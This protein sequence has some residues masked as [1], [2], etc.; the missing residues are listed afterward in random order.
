MFQLGSRTIDE[1]K[2]TQPG[3][4]TSVRQQMADLKSA[5]LQYRKDYEMADGRVK[6]LGS[7]REKKVT[8]NKVVFRNIIIQRSDNHIALSMMYFFST[9]NIFFSEYQ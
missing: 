4:Y 2:V 9:G 6:E 3:Q 1:D 5:K 8:A 7:E